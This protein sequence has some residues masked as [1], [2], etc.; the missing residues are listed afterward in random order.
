MSFFIFKSAHP[1]GELGE[2]VRKTYGAFAQLNYALMTPFNQHDLRIPANV[3][4]YSRYVNEVLYRSPAALAVMGLIAFA[5]TYH[6]LNWFSKT[7]IIQW[8]NMPRS[9]LIAVIVIWLAS[10]GAYTYNYVFGL[11]WLYFLAFTHVLLE[12]PL[13]HLTII[14]IGKEFKTIVV[15]RA[16]M[17]RA[18]RA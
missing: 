17:R 12:F 6:Y 8:H 1:A 16:P 10:I 11:R 2:S 9:R 14:N 4:Q 7:S 5:Y 15:R 18:E 3:L 13:N